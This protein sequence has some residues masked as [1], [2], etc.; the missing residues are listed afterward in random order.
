MQ[1]M[2]DLTLFPSG[3]ADSIIFAGSAMKAALLLQNLRGE[4]NQF[5][6]MPTNCAN[7]V[8]GGCLSLSFIK[9]SWC[10]FNLFFFLLQLPGSEIFP[11]GSCKFSPKWLAFS[12]PASVESFLLYS[13]LLLCEINRKGELKQNL[14]FCDIQSRNIYSQQSY[15]VSR[16]VMLL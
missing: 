4:E 3:R 10:I 13:R 15:P 7:R 1:L 14:L 12:F 11:S 16:I 2:S 5:P 8:V 9:L 6:R